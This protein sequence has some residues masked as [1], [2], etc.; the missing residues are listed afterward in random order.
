LDSSGRDEIVRW[1]EEDMLRSGGE[2]EIEILGEEDIVYLGF[3]LEFI[4]L[5]YLIIIMF[6]DIEAEYTLRR[7]ELQTKLSEV[8]AD[9]DKLS[10]PVT[11]HILASVNLVFST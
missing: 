9:L 11:N 10:D 2:G 1:M 4:L 6:K 8:K 7:K 5:N 3:E